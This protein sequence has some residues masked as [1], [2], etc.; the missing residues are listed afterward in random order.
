MLLDRANYE[1]KWQAWLELIA[2]THHGANHRVNPIA[3]LAPLAV[4][5]SEATVALVTTAG[6][7]LDSQLPFHVE[8]VAGDSGYRLIP[9]DVELGELRFTHTHYDTTSAERDPNVVFP[10]VRLHELVS[11]GR[12]GTASPVHVGMMGFNPDPT[13]VAEVSAP[14][15]V[16]ALVEAGVHAAV[17]A[18]G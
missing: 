8:T 11:T 5:L 12:I 16:G 15:I 10:I 9:D 13:D 2:T 17:L 1:E 18:P 7:H 4:P 14:A 6:V 3:E